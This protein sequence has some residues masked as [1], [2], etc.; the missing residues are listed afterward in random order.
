MDNLLTGL[1]GGELVIVGA[2]PSM[3]KTSWHEPDRLRGDDGGQ[4]DGGF[5]R[6]KCRRISSRCLR[7]RMRVDMQSVRHGRCATTT[8]SCPP[9]LTR[10]R[11]HIYIDDTGITSQLR[12]AA[13]G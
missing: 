10:W 9:R 1:H 3:G 5:P 12:P 7:A 11:L 8:D 13:E 4:D 2:R 6:W